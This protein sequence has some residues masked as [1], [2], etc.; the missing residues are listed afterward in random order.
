MNRREFLRS[1]STSVAGIALG[2]VG[3]SVIGSPS[4]F[5]RIIGSNDRVRVGLVGFSDRSKNTLIPCF[6][7]HAAQLNFEIVAVSDIWNRRRDEAIAFFKKQY[8]QTITAYRN[9][10]EMYS[11]A[12]LDAVIV[13][14]ADFQHALHAIEA[15]QAGCDAYVEKPFAETMADNRAALKAVRS[16][17]RIVQILVRN[18]AAART[19]TQPMIT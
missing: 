19:T 12:G 5:A 14:T 11:Q 4:S 9:N 13:G 16:T 10:E 7:Q 2:A 18:A 3:L 17:D 8:G 6:Q 1:S 15:V